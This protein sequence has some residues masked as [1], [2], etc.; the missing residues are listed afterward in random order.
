MSTDEP[1][2]RGGRRPSGRAA[3]RDAGRERAEAQRRDRPSREQRIEQRDAQRA[4]RRDGPAPV[5]PVWARPEPGARRASLTREDI[6]NAGLAIG[7]AEGLDAISMRRI[8]AELGVGTMTLYYYVRNKEELLDLMHDAIMGEVIVPDLEL[9]VDWRGALTAIAERTR[10]TMLRHPWSVGSPPTTSGPNG[11]RH[12][13]QSLAAVAPLGLDLAQRFDII[14]AIDDY[15]FGY[16]LR[17]LEQAREDAGPFADR[18]WVEAL[19]GYFE[20]QWSSGAF[21][22]VQALVEQDGSRALMER[23]GELSHDAGRF[24]RGLDWV[25][26]GIERSVS[27]GSPR[28]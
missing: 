21:P 6:A 24:R 11:M 13:E 23:L 16:L 22:E 3:S 8:A 10:S 18:E 26:D 27:P 12:F 2:R 15:T 17:E 4:Q 1:P 25:L 9:P 20:A 7:D 5:G 19:A 14:C 28:G